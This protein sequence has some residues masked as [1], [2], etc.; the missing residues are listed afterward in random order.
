MSWHTEL[1]QKLAVTIARKAA[2]ESRANLES[3][4]NSITDALRAIG[5]I[6]DLQ[7]AIQYQDPAHKAVA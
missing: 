4:A 7:Q 1:E 6:P 3:R 5:L 2:T